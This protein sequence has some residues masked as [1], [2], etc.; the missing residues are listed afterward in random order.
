LSTITVATNFDSGYLTRAITLFH[1]LRSNEPVQFEV[2]ALDTLAELAVA[3]LPSTNVTQIRKFLERNPHVATAIEPLNKAER[4]FA[5]GPSFLLE[6]M[7]KVPDGGWLIYCDAD[8][9]F[10]RGIDEYMSSFGEASV[11]IVPHN[12]YPWN[13]KRLAKYGEF[14]VGLV[15]FRNDEDG[16]EVLEFWAK[17]CL[18][19]CRDI[20][21]SDRYADQKY[22]ESFPSITKKVAVDR[23]V[24]SNLAPWNSS[25]RDFGR[26]GSEVLV[27]GQPLYFFH[28]QGLKRDEK[29]WILGHLQ[30]WSLAGPTLRRLIYVPYLAA[31]EG[32]AGRLGTASQA[33]V[34]QSAS[35]LRRLVSAGLKIAAVILG[36]RISFSK[37]DRNAQ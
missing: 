6:S 30:Y 5:T 8:L 22:L 20:P 26:N 17:S 1:S 13:R 27:D 2:L 15:A 33:N 21:D 14:N 24:G 35:N 10:Y 9:V 25:L 29:G 28:M 4:I 11:V 23:R 7:S 32:N 3:D 12:H 34:R 18:E 16:R 37:L 36:Q 31:L 19:W